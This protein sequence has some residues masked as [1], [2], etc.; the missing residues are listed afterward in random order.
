MSHIVDDYG[1]PDTIHC[2]Q[3]ITAPTLIIA[4]RKNCTVV[5]W[6]LKN[7]GG[8]L[9]LHGAQYTITAFTQH[10]LLT[11]ILQIKF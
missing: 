7:D 1:N 2:Q 11:M 9:H 6:K 10:T 3:P 5:Q 8:G 4:H